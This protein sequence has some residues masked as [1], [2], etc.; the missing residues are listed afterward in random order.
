MK[1]TLAVILAGGVGSRLHPLTKDRAKPSVPFGGI[2]RIV[3]F[4]L[5]NCLH[6]GLRRILVL[7]QYK[8]HSLNKHLR[9]GWSVFNPELGEYITPIPAQMQMGDEWY[10]GTADAIY[11]NRHILKRSN[12]KYVLVLAGDH[13]YRMDYAEMLKIHI[14]QK[15]DVTIACMPVPMRLADAFGVIEIDSDHRIRRFVE[16]VKDPPSMPG[17]PDHVLA[18]MGIYIFNLPFLLK[19]L[20][21]DH[22]D[23]ASAHDFGRNILPALIHAHTHTVGAYHFGGEE[24]R[25]TQDNYWRDVGTLDAYYQAN[26]DLLGPAPPI[27]LY[28]KEWPIRTYHGQY[29]SARMVPSPS[30]EVGLVEN[31][32]LAGGDLV[33]GARVIYSILSYDVRV[34]SGAF[35]EES[36]LFEGVRV[37]RGARLRR[38]IVDK[39]VAIPPGTEIGWDRDEDEKRFTLSE[40]GIVVVPKGYQFPPSDPPA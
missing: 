20:A 39:G 23:A 29:P 21:K 10:A 2:Y 31:A 26:M 15:R 11:Q 4:T 27:D 13:I 14:D 28:Q 3:D 12:I 1:K 24:G 37:G 6:S 9:D 25:V 40:G 38:C 35:V 22:K 16:K 7:T 33:I 30:G 17:D 19:I 8:S 32:S 34:E 36:I 5:S 18:S